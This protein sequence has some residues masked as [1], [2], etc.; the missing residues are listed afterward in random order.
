LEPV[1]YATE[2]GKSIGFQEVLLTIYLLGVIYYFIKLVYGYKVAALQKR[3]EKIVN[4]INFYVSEDNVRAF[5]FLNRIFIA[6]NI[7]KHP[8]IAV[9]LKHE[10][11]HSR[12]NIFMIF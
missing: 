5:T 11:V 12:E 8:S 4:G 2:A 10:S 7:L 1:T 6:K 3:W 9:V